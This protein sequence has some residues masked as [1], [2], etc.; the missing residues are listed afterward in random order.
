MDPTLSPSELTGLFESYTGEMLDAYFPSK[1]IRLK[2]DDK[3]FITEKI[4]S[5]KRQLMREYERNGK[6]VKYLSLKESLDSQIA[7]AVDKYKEKIID[8]VKNGSKTSTSA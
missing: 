1:Q 8:N 5:V 3:P 6:S 7:T 2:S 4:K